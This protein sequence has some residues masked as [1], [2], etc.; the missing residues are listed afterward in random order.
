MRDYREMASRVFARRD[1]YLKKKKRLRR[2]AMLGAGCLALAILAGSSIWLLRP[3]EVF[4]QA[5]AVLQAPQLD[6]A[7]TSEEAEQVMTPRHEREQ[8][9][10]P[11]DAPPDIVP[12][13][14]A[15]EPDEPP[16][17][18]WQDPQPEAQE[19]GDPEL[20]Q[21]PPATKQKDPDQGEIVDVGPPRWE[22]A[23]A[24]QDPGELSATPTV[25]A[26]WD[27]RFY[28]GSYYD[29]DGQFVVLLTENTEENQEKVCALHHFDKSSTVFKTA[30]FELG[31]LSALLKEISE[32]MAAGE[33]PFVVSCW[34]DETQNRVV[35]QVTTEDEGLLQSLYEMDR[36][37]GA[38][39]IVQD[40]APAA[41][42]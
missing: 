31:F 17:V 32:R 38:L 22:D 37:V 13:E 7:P 40:E 24:Q 29:E 25:E 1:E 3:P 2:G 42:E 15:P 23:P 8:G 26:D 14:A 11:T 4:S 9:A 5:P 10:D 21:L 20:C 12:E 36:G 27:Y 34:I 16:E 41:F 30:E 33:L 19:E 39:V 18:E 35:A 28:A 6:P